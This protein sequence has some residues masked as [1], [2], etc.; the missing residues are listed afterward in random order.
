MGA[1][2]VCARARASGKDARTRGKCA[3]VG[4]ERCVGD[5][6][7]P[8]V[9]HVFALHVSSSASACVGVWAASP[10]WVPFLALWQLSLYFSRSFSTSRSLRQ[11]CDERRLGELGTT[12]TCS[13][14]WVLT[15]P[16]RK[17]PTRRSIHTHTKKQN[18]MRKRAPSQMIAGAVRTQRERE[19][20]RERGEIQ[21]VR[22]C[23]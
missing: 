9:A 13:C 3:S 17:A 12:C 18:E 19:R 1:A 4:G 10:F 21:C 14:P 20:G 23:V 15:A 16:P 22:V 11:Q 8:S 7:P 6:S 2:R 5:V